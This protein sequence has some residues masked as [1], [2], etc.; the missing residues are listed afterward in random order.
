MTKANNHASRRR[1]LEIKVIPPAYL[2][3]TLAASARLLGNDPLL[4]PEGLG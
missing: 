3:M 2:D 4:R 1:K